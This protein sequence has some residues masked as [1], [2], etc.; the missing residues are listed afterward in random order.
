[1]NDEIEP[2]VLPAE[3]MPKGAS[4]QDLGLP[5]ASLPSRL[6]EIELLA[7]F[8]LPHPSDNAVGEV[9]FVSSPGFASGLALGGLAVEE[10]LRGWVVSGLGDRGD[11]EHRVDRSVATEIE[12]M[13]NWQAN[14]LG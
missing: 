5:H 3:V 1:M 11:V 8:V 9:A 6:F 4:M 7:S 12:A 14:A 2:A 10:G 13:P